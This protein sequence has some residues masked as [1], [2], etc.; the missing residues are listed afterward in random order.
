MKKYILLLL[1]TCSIGNAQYNLFARQNFAKS[2]SAIT[3][4]TEIG[5]VS[6]TI[7]T[8]ALLATKLGIDVSRI[9]NFTIIGSDIKCKITGSYAIPPGAFQFNT[10][11]CT[12][13]RDTD[14]LVSD[15]NDS[16]FYAMDIVDTIIRIYEFKNATS[17]NYS[18][19]QGAFR[20]SNAE[21][22]HLDNCINVSQYA[23]SY[24]PY[25]K[26]VYIPRATTLGNTSEN[27]F[28][29]DNIPSTAIIF[30]HPS[31]ATNNSG[32]PDG[33]LAYAISQGATVRYV[34]NFTA[35]NPVTDLSGTQN[36]RDMQLNFTP[37]TGSTNAIDY[38][39]VYVNGIF[40]KNITASGQFISPL[41]K[42]DD[43][44][45]F[46]IKLIAVDIFYNKSIES[47]VFTFIKNTTAP[48]PVTTLS[49]G[50]IYNTA[51]QLNFTPP[52]GSTN[53]IDYYEVYVNGIF[54]KNITAS[55]QFITGLTPN[56]SYNITLKAVDIFYN[57]SVVSNN[58]SISTSSVNPTDADATAYI[59]ASSNS[60]YSTII[61]DLFCELKGSNLY[62][63]IQAFYLFLGTT[64][65]QHKWN[66]KNPLDTDSAFRLNFI[67]GATYTD[68]GYTPNGTTGYANSFFIPSSSQSVNNNGVTLV[69]GTNNA[70][71]NSNVFDL[72]VFQSTTQTTILSLKNNN[73]NYEKRV[74]V[75]N[76]LTI[77]LTGI[78]EAKG[79]Y[80]AVRQS[81]II[82]KLF[83]NG[84]LLGSRTAGGILPSISI[85][86]GAFESKRKL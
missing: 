68:L 15:I 52:T 3:Y 74:A 12:Y 35:P 51:I 75:N 24:N 69:S 28:V 41:I 57:K 9:S 11:P 39:E 27:N 64:A 2:A 20:R 62:P 76:Y 54:E 14:S 13:F 83:R 19:N 60:G 70:T 67:G 80:S 85:G 23:F 58:L 43:V 21:F 38:Y 6:A 81:S 45:V 10:N 56:T 78:N 18:S 77:S 40:E 30:C 82:G 26:R 53:A 8:P 4:N 25:L 46:D 48:N 1:L 79:I 29:F 49:A 37:P 63:K 32:A 36:V 86:I 47:N 42:N 84:S 55:G 5:G 66:A 65:A 71:A 72:G 50:T 59:T 16:A 73:T 17:V 33:D 34:T 61:N 7:S 22:I 31:L 44:S